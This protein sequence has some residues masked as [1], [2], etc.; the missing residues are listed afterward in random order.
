MAIEAK[1]C[2]LRDA[3][4]VNA[5]LKGGARYI[6]F[7]FYPPSPRS[8]TPATAAELA[9]HAAGRAGCVGLFVDPDDDTLASITRAVP[10]DMIQLHGDESP[11]RVA[12]IRE[13][14]G[15]PVMKALKISVPEDLAGVEAYLPVADRLLFDAKA[16]KGKADALPGGNA[17]AFDWRILAGKSWSRP[18]MLAGGINPENLAE[19]VEVSGARSVDVSSGVEVKPGQKDPERIALFLQKARSL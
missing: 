7:V 15:R 9:R 3:A 16:P 12:D 4:S 2:G 5:A 18:W 8:I 13:R 6:G 17:V 10:L 1:I 11:A 19:A 14:Y